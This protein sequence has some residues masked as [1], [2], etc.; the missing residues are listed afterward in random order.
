CDYLLVEGPL[1]DTWPPAG[2]KR[3]FGELPIREFVAKDHPGV[4][5]PPRSPDRQQ[6]FMGKNKP[7]PVPGIW[8]VTS[9]KP[10][11]DADRLLAEFLPRAFRRPVSAEVRKQY[12][13]RVTERLK[14]G[15]CFEVAMRWAYRAALCSPAFLYPVEPAGELDD[16]ALACRLSYFLWNSMPD[17]KLTALA[18]AGKLMHRD[19]LRGEVERMLADDRSKRFVDDFVGQWL[20]LRQISANDPDK[21]L[22]PE[23]SKYLEDSMLA[24]SRAYFRELLDKDLTADHLVKS[25]FAM[26]NQKL[27]AHYGIPGV[28]GCQIRRVQLPAACPRGGYLTQAAILKI[29]ANGTTTSP[30]PPRAFGV[31]RLLRNTPE[32]P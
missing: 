7:D 12:V 10:L 3:L 9:D 22:Y 27:A 24:E 4:R 16:Y 6:L 13:D 1:H 14:A 19:A 20:K 5:H 21:K 17:E 2:H 11:E 28:S 25:D 8:T 31:D 23:F 18:A 30:G 29:T 32:P 26:L 15:D